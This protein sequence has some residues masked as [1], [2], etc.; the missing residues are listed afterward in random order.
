MLFNQVAA[1]AGL[2]QV[3][4]VQGFENVESDLRVVSD[5]PSDVPLWERIK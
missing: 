4:E 3:R 2:K 5:D 1:L